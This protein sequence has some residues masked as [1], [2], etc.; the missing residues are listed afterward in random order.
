VVGTIVGLSRLADTLGR[1]FGGRLSDV[2]GTRRVVLFGVLLTV[3]MF[4]FLVYGTGFLTFLIPLSFMT[5]GFGL[6]NVSGVTCALQTAGSAAKGVGLGLARASNSSGSMLG[7]LLAG[8]LI[9]QFDFEGGF[10]AMA[11][12][13]LAIFLAVW[14]AFRREN[15]NNAQSNYIDPGG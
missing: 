15:K 1:F 7:P 3:P 8:V 14:T 2:L 5:L 12:I 9:Q 11:L 6:T 13:S 10:L 4:L